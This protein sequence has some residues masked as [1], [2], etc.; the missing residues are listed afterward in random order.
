M[1]VYQSMRGGGHTAAS[2]DQVLRTGESEPCGVCAGEP[3]F[4]ASRVDP[5]I[6][7]FSR[8][9]GSRFET[10]CRQQEAALLISH[11]DIEQK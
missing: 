8:F 2:L 4:L 9:E 1:S 6:A 5:R 7:R 10:P 3:A 11:L